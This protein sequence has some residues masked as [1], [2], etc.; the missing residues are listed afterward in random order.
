[1]SW[2][3][4]AAGWIAVEVRSFSGSRCE[5]CSGA[6]L[7][8]LAV[9]MSGVLRPPQAPAPRSAGTRG[10][11]GLAR[12]VRTGLRTR[13]RR[14]VIPMPTRNAK[15]A[16]NPIDVQ[17]FDHTGQRAKRPSQPAETAA[18]NPR[19][20]TQRGSAPVVRIATAYSGVATAQLKTLPK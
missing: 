6:E 2:H 7:P 11:S 4:V 5:R 3:R 18:I 12:R 10:V 19:Y 8:D 15:K 14:I 1:M 17:P 9:A 16:R 13:R 20:P